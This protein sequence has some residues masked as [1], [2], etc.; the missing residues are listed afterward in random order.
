[1]RN[2]RKQYTYNKVHTTATCAKIMKILAAADEARDI[3]NAKSPSGMV[4][5]DDEG[6]NYLGAL[7]N[8]Q[9]EDQ[10]TY[11]EAYATTCDSESL[12]R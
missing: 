10:S 8:S 2:I 11:G 3:R 4:N 5:A 7:V 12:A 6:L 9:H 1:M